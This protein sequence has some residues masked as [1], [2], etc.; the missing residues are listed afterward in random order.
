MRISE[1]RRYP[2]KSMA[3]VRL[4]RACLE[5]SGIPG[6]RVVHVEDENGRI[7]NC[8]DSSL[9]CVGTMQSWT[10]SVFGH[11]R[12]RLRPNIVTGSVNHLRLGMLPAAHTPSE[13]LEEGIFDKS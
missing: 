5:S 6:D 9:A 3:G 2:I 11:D 1:L 7:I 10:L 4:E 8:K 12:R 13:K